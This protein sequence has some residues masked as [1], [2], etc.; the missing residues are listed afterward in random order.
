MAE[1]AEGSESDE[2]SE[3]SLDPMRGETGSMAEDQSPIRDQASIQVE[4]EV[5]RGPYK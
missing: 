1:A 4:R 3:N 5:K 2:G